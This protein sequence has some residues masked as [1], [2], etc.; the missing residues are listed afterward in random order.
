MVSSVAC[1]GH[2][3]MAVSVRGTVWTWG[4]NEESGVLG[5]GPDPA[6]YIATPTLIAGR[7]KIQAERVATTGWTSFYISDVGRLSSWGGGVCGVHGHDHLED[8]PV[9]RPVRVLDRVVLTHMACG[10]L[11]VLALTSDGCVLTWGRVAGAFDA[12]VSVLKVPQ[13]IDKL[14]GM[15]VVQVAAGG[16][17]SLA[18]TERGEVYG[19]GDQSR[20]ALGKA[21]PVSARFAEVRQTFLGPAR[22]SEIGCGF[23]HTICLGS[24]GIAKIKT[25]F[26][27]GSGMHEGDHI[28]R[29]V[30]SVSAVDAVWG[31]PLAGAD[32]AS[33][34]PTLVDMWLVMNQTG[35]EHRLCRPC[36][37]A[38]GGGHPCGACP[39]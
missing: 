10:S 38:P 36:L 20:G 31:R 32:C 27:C 17:H 14:C 13:V 37:S 12:S 3:S 30:D 21:V 6:K 25:H 33:L 19:W 26:L 9:A 8:E 2:I 16:D 1:G 15:R 39:S 29:R 28:G 24:S 22:V 7:Q 34:D 35:A 5:V 4:K 18:L 23:A 11:H